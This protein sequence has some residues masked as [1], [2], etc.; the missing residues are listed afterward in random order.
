M[1]RWYRSGTSSE[2]ARATAFLLAALQPAPVTM[3]SVATSYTKDIARVTQSHDAMRNRIFG[4]L[5]FLLSLWFALTIVTILQRRRLRTQAIREYLDDDPDEEI[6]AEF[7]LRGKD[8]LARPYSNFLALG[9][10]MILLSH[11]L[12]LL[13][14]L[15]NL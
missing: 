6:A 10:V 1:L 13:W 9:L 5:A 8:A 7:L 4:V 11:I 12:G 15:W 2:K 3:Q 14:V